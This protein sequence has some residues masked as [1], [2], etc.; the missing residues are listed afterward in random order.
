MRS[1]PVC[2]AASRFA[3]G[4]L[5]TALF[6]QEPAKPAPKGELPKRPA[7]AAELFAAFAKMPGL[8]A[9]YTEDKHLQLLEVPLQSKGRLY[10]LPPGYLLR[11]VE[12]PEKS[13]LLITPKELRMQNRDG[14][15]VVDL[16]QSERLRTFVTSL[17][18]V[19]GG[20]REELER[21][22][23]VEFVASKDD[24]TT[25]RLELL[26]R[27]KPLDQMLKGLVLAGNGF[28][29]TTITVFEPN[30]DRTETRIEQADPKR[31]FDR[32]EKKKLFGIADEKAAGGEKAR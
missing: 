31:A 28:A 2:R 12:A 27:G 20:D 22:Y 18:R 9:R 23:K 10:F 21:Q 13:T 5:A 15:E 32:E 30:G 4:L 16:G 25:W 19:F 1:W 29:V 17:V 14:T 7:D 26:P 3:C 11:M 8:E 24:A 6:A